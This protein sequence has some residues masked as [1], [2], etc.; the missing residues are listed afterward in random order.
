MQLP[1]L[2]RSSSQNQIWSC[3]CHANINN[4]QYSDRHIDTDLQFEVFKEAK[5]M[6]MILCIN[7]NFKIVFRIFSNIC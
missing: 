2:Q 1:G 7:V 5:T 4:L 3:N 6:D